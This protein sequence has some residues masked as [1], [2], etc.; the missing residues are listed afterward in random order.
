MVSI[1]KAHVST[2]MSYWSTKSKLHIAFLVCKIYGNIN[3]SK[4]MSVSKCK[5]LY[6]LHLRK[7]YLKQIYS[8][9]RSL[10]TLQLSVCSRFITI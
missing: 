2:L 4:E 3:W 5:S 6:C 1:R 9:Q 10:N 7:Y 8:I